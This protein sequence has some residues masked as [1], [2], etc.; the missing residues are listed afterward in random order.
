MIARGSLAEE[1][2]RMGESL[3]PYK[4]LNTLN[5]HEP[6]FGS[7]ML[8]RTSIERSFDKVSPP[9]GGAWINRFQHTVHC[10]SH[11]YEE[12][13]TRLLKFAAYC[14]SR[15]TLTQDPIFDARLSDTG[16]R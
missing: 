10:V 5:T 11:L 7:R 14:P 12:Q 6:M 4:F 3:A 2:I 16:G 15:R 8:R 1:E 9:L 13:R